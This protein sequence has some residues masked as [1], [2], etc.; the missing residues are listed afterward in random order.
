MVED[1]NT[2]GALAL[3]LPL[4][5]KFVNTKQKSTEYFNTLLR[6]LLIQQYLRSIIIETSY[7]ERFTVDNS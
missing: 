6:F 3:L 1:H 4:D 2:A 7:E 5:V